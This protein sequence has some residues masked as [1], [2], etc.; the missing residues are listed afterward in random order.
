MVPGVGDTMVNKWTRSCPRGVHCLLVKADLKST[1]KYIFTNDGEGVLRWGERSGTL[2]RR[3]LS[4]LNSAM[5]VAWGRVLHAEE[6]EGTQCLQRTD[7][8]VVRR[9]P[10]QARQWYSWS[11]RERQGPDHTGPVD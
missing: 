4:L 6:G 8:K 10:G 11:W 3:T 2:F 5:H 1:Y 7:R 9:R